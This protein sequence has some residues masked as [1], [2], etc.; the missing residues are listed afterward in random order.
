[1]MG[2]V[3]VAG[4]STDDE[5]GYK[6]PIDKIAAGDKLTWKAIFHATRP[7]ASVK[8]TAAEPNAYCD[9][10]RRFATT[11]VECTKQRSSPE[12]LLPEPPQGS[13]SASPQAVPM[14]IPMFG[15][16]PYEKI[17]SERHS[18]NMYVPM[19]VGLNPVATDNVA[20]A[21]EKSTIPEEGDNYENGRIESVETDGESSGEDCGMGGYDMPKPTNIYAEIPGSD[22]QVEESHIYEC[23][24]DIKVRVQSGVVDAA[25]A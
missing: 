9:I 23:L 3:A 14:Y 22:C 19:T 20:Y 15:G 10:P 12:E 11:N 16:S 13:A 7:H 25:E 1:M 6:K 21:N 17:P 5:E 24:D 18:V 4:E 2:A 8:A